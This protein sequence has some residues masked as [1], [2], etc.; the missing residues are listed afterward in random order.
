MP[1]RGARRV[2]P[3]SRGERGPPEAGPGRRSGADP[4]HCAC[5]KLLS[6]NV[7]R[8]ERPAAFPRAVLPFRHKCL[9]AE[10]PRG[11]PARVSASAEARVRLLRP[12]VIRRDG[13][14]ARRGP[15]G[16]CCC[17]GSV[18]SLAR[19]GRRHCRC[20]QQNRTPNAAAEDRLCNP[21]RGARPIARTPG[22]AGAARAIRLAWS[23]RLHNGC[24][25]AQRACIFPPPRGAP[26]RSCAISV[27]QLLASG[28]APVRDRDL[29]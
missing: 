1:R 20:R 6:P 14:R 15:G 7:L 21:P 27:T 8:S 26:P 11:T 10:R 19:V 17:A 24:E 3:G 25:R 16:T 4:R 22:G 13:A 18:A 29:E 5:H 23:A 28:R 2:I 12:C 9:R